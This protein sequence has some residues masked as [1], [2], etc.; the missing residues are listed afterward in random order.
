MH[1]TVQKVFTSPSHNMNLKHAVGGE[2]D[3]DDD[4][5]DND[6]DNRSDCDDDGGDGR[7]PWTPICRP[8]V[9]HV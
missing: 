3:D 8:C 7:L 5:D 6:D 4:D 9:D 2:G 1:L